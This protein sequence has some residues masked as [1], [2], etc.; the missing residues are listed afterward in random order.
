MRATLERPSAPSA[1]EVA[2]DIRPVMLLT[3]NVPFEEPAVE[4]AV[5]TAAET[6]AELYICDAIP[7]P[8]AN[9]VTQIARSFAEQDNRKYLNSVARRSRERGVRTTQMVFHNPKPIRAALE[10]VREQS[11]GLL[12][13]GADRRMLGRWFFR[14]AARRLRQEAACLV[15]T[16]E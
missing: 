6:G 13:F 1:V 14:R 11:I 10:V 2:R 15:W 12:V 3:L 4:F 5:D 16:N 7:L 8:Y 9:Y